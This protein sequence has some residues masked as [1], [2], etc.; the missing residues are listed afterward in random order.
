MLSF[1]RYDLECLLAKKSEI[2]EAL[3]KCINE[4]KDFEDSITVGT[5]E[6]RR[7]EYRLRIWLHQM[8]IIMSENV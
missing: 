8:D 1:E 2:I 4:D 7:L 3:K 5:S 6:P